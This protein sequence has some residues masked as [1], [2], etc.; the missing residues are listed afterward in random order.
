MIKFCCTL[1]CGWNLSLYRFK[2]LVTQA[3]WTIV[4]ATQIVVVNVGD[5]R[6]ILLQNSENNDENSGALTEATGNMSLQ[7][8]TTIPCADPCA[9][10]KP[11]SQRN[12]RLEFTVTAL[13]TDHKPSLDSERSRVEE[14]GLVVMEERFHDADGVEQTIHKV[15]L[16]DG[17]RMACSRSFGDFE[18]KT[19]TEKSAD[20]Q[21]VTAAPEVN[22]HERSSSD[23]FLVAACDGVWDVMSNQDVATFVAGRLEHYDTGNQ[24]DRSLLLPTIANELLI[25]CIS[26]GASDN[27]SVTLAA[28]SNWA[29]K[30]SDKSS[31]K[32]KIAF[33]I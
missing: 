2:I 16:S 33:E 26:R 3:V 8:R 4:T 23:A 28:L 22:V 11:L 14:A 19:N 6:C 18:Y 5:C 31:T 17:Q 21:A 20:Q 10:M 32:R 29:D 9:E 13:S 25:E 15:K 24:P 12:K 27:L 1:C 7:D 30:L